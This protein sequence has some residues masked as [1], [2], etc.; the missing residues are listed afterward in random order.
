[1]DAPEPRGRS[2]THPRVP[3]EAC[4]ELI[5]KI[6][7][8]IGRTA[9]DRNQ[10]GTILGFKGLNGGSAKVLATLAEVGLLEKAGDG[11]RLTDLAGKILRPIDEEDRQANIRNSFF[12]SD[13]N[14]EVYEAFEGQG[15]L[16]GALQVLLER[17]HGILPDAAKPAAD[18]FRL[19]I[20]FA[21]LVS[22]DG[23]YIAAEEG[24][25]DSRNEEE[26][27]S[28]SR[29]MHDNSGMGT[30]RSRILPTR[31]THEV[32]MADLECR[33]VIGQPS[34]L[35]EAR[36]IERWFAVVVSPW[37]KFTL[38]PALIA[39]GQQVADEEKN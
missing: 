33:V 8:E 29:K 13:F 16:P 32:E 2:R 37:L 23:V 14:R 21:G 18:V 28:N 4:V 19:S 31:L 26:F 35:E 30:P 9:V 17:N 34:T 24:E 25:P 39:G 36:R 15:R 22:P 38:E 10:M 27:G 12:S 11:L 7:A 1:M 20:T 5:T 3:L 6:N